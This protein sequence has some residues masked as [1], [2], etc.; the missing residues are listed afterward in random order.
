M[1]ETCWTVEQD[2]DRIRPLMEIRECQTPYDVQITDILEPLDEV[3]N[4]ESSSTR[5]LHQDL[6]T[7]ERVLEVSIMLLQYEVQDEDRVREFIFR[8]SGMM[9]VLGALK[10]LICDLFEPDVRVSLRVTGGS[11]DTGSQMLF[12]YIMTSL[13]AE[14]AVALLDRLDFDWLLQQ[15]ESVR[16]CFDVNLRFV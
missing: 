15:P 14:Q 12:A 6:W 1:L 9:S 3:W 16:K 4:A 8:H 11:G 13:A 10:G 2:R 7:T 5:G